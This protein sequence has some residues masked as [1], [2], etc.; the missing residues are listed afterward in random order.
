MFFRLLFAEHMAG[1][2]LLQFDVVV[3]TALA[4]F[5]YS[6]GHHDTV[7]DVSNRVCDR[8]LPE[9]NKLERPF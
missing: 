3:L 2:P 7:W 1:L 5:N 6:T 9:L 4:L 8:Y